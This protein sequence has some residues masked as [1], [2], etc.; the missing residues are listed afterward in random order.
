M[1]RA[2]ALVYALLVMLMI[3][4]FSSGLLLM[5]YLNNKV[6][7]LDNQL[8]YKEQLLSDGMSLFLEIE[9]TYEY[10][11]EIPYSLYQEE[12]SNLIF[13]KKKWGLYDVLI[14]KT[15]NKKPVY[16]NALIGKIASDKMN[17]SVYLTDN[18]KPLVLTGNTLI[19][20]NVELPKN[21]VQQGYLDGKP[22]ENKKLVNGTV[23]YSTNQLPIIDTDR[24]MNMYN[25]SLDNVEYKIEF[26][27]I[28]QSFTKPTKVILLE[29][30]STLQN[31]KMKGNILLL[32]KHTLRIK[33]NTHIESCIIVAPNI[34]VENGTTGTMQLFAKDT[35]WIG[36]NVTL[37]YPSIVCVNGSSSKSIV[38]I[39]E[40]TKIYGEIYSLYPS[41][42]RTT[43][44]PQLETE[45]NS[46]IMGF[47]YVQGNAKLEGVINGTI[48]TN[49]FVYNTV[50]SI[51]V[52]YLFNT[53][54]DLTKR[55]HNFLFSKIVSQPL[56]TSNVIQWVN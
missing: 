54:I 3:S 31:I 17:L 45:N 50:Q 5:V 41:Q 1:F 52:N 15:D 30:P 33:N 35:L 42:F 6:T 13:E 7:N 8:L 37:N 38:H 40:N 32:C 36:N 16:K 56:K 2:Y 9:S 27:S 44:A 55:N 21:G 23:A 4:L 19:N 24:I 47:C 11:K 39:S 25:L 14:E 18:F 34:K 49:A 48:W 20:G 53:T 26:D 51:Y 46:T 10:N 29:E 12:K 43:Y 28:E 22:Y